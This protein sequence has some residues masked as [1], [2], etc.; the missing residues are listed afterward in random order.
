MEKRIDLLDE[1]C[2]I[3]VQGLTKLLEPS[4][5]MLVLDM[6]HQALE[7]GYHYFQD[8]SSGESYWD[9]HHCMGCLA[10]YSYNRAKLLLSYHLEELSLSLPP[11]TQC[12][13]EAPRIQVLHECNSSINTQLR[14]PGK[15][16]YRV[17]C[18]RCR[19]STSVTKKNTISEAIQDWID[20]YCEYL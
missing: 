17:L 12:Y 8:S 2:I 11:C 13:G 10:H 3:V 4:A 14:I 9:M 19:W 5:E 1:F 20:D 18:E 15:D 6:Y 16:R 7:E